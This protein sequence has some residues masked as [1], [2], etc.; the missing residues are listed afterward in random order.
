MFRFRNF[1]GRAFRRELEEKIHELENAGGGGT[2]DALLQENNLSDVD[3]VSESR[4]NLD[5]YST[6]DTDDNISSAISDHEG[7]DDPH[8]QYAKDSD[9]S[10]VAT[11]GDYDDLSNTP[12]LAPVAT[13]GEY[14]DLSGKPE[15]ADV[16][17]SG[18]Y[19]DLSGTPDLA[20]VAE[21][22]DY[23]DLTNKPDLATVATSGDYDDLSNKPD[24]PDVTVS[25]SDPSGTPNDG[26]IWMKV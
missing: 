12:D 4:D 22:G 18:E 26:D 10:D 16:A 13:S 3:S 2:D 17:T 23:D 14:D 5:V 8:S 20:T 6:T 24:V 21:T 9:L 7:A 1:F 25:T 19:N 15:L 11:S